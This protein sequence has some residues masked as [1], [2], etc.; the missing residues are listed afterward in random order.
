MLAPDLPGIGENLSIA[1]GDATLA[2][3]GD[4]V[5]ALARAAEPPVI[6]VGHSRGGL[7]IGEASER[8][9]EL[10]AGLIYV[11]GLIVPL[12][13]TALEVMEPHTSGDG[14]PLTEE[15]KAFWLPGETAIPLFYQR[16]SPSD[17]A[18]VAAHV[19]PEALAPIATPATVTKQQ[20]STIPRAYIETSDDRTLSLAR[21]RSIQAA[22]PCNPVMTIDSDHYPF[23]SA[24]DELADVLVT[25]A[26]GFVE[27]YSMPKII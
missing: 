12:G 2:L 21:Q 19:C 9:P 4:Y 26:I 27:R 23:L 3:W 17:A 10:I 1:A 8:V 5:A 16:C 11:S 14:P 25:I 20:W 22:A 18:A 6:L 13:L 15:G 7:V 24:A